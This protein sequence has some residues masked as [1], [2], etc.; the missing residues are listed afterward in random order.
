[1][2]TVSGLLTKMR[3]GLKLTRPGRDEGGVRGRRAA[4]GLVPG[5]KTREKIV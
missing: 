3:Q 5:L 1:M 2:L 4:S